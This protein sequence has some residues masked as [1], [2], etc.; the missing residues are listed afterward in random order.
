MKKII[1]VSTLILMSFCSC[2]HSTGTNTEKTVETPDLNVNFRLYQTNN[3]WTFL[4]L[5]T[6]NGIITHV[7]YGIDEEALEYPLNT[8][9]LAEDSEAKTGRFFLY[10]TE[11]TFTY[12]LLDQIDGRVWQVQWNIDKENRGMW[13]IKYSAFS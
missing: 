1:W 12:I 2:T 13:V 10:P 8:L 9:P 5:D 3:I 4:K 11:N 7:Q 6:R